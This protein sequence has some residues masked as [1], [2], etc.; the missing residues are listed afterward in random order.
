[1][2]EGKF[3]DRVYPDNPEQQL[4]FDGM[5]GV[6]NVWVNVHCVIELEFFTTARQAPSQLVNVLI[7]MKLWKNGVNVNLKN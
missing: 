6:R 1:M 4:I 2:Y 3:I 5:K 7:A